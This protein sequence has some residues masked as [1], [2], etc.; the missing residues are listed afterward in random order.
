MKLTSS[1]AKITTL[2]TTQTAK[3]K[4]K[5]LLSDS[6]VSNMSAYGFCILG[7]ICSMIN[8]VRFISSF[9]L[10]LS[11]LP[12]HART[13]WFRAPRHKVTRLLFLGGGVLEKGYSGYSRDA[14]TDFDAKYVKRRGSALGSAFWGSRNQNV[15]FQPSFSPKTAIFG[16]HF[17]GT[18]NFF[19]PKTAFNIGP[20]ES[21]R[22]L[23]V[24]VAQ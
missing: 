12:S 6:H 18:W 3:T 7:G 20:L 13:A 8:D 9:N 10:V 5:L 14:C 11:S 21:K 15:R 22:P 16:P 19:G 23:I 4:K 17:D 24:V 2:H 1:K